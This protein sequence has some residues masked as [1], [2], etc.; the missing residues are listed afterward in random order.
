MRSFFC[1]PPLAYPTH[2]LTVPSAARVYAT[3]CRPQ[4]PTAGE[5]LRWMQVGLQL[6]LFSITKASLRA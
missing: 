6:S 2:H 3:T 5:M 1:M 4:A